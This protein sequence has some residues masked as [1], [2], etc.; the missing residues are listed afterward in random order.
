MTQLHKIKYWLKL[1]NLFFGP[2]IARII[3]YSDL[4][5]TRFLLGVA[6]LIWGITL[7]LP[8]QTFGRP[9]YH[10]MSFVMSEECWGAVFLMTSFLQFTILLS[11]RYHD[12]VS[13]VFAAW[14]TLLWLFVVGGMYMSVY[15][16]PAGISGELTLALAAGWVFARSGFTIEGRRS[17]DYGQ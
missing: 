4:H 15:P 14:N 8:G 1:A 3:F 11:G 10:V 5:G 9:T 17:T 7:L 6:E 12:R 16:I 2:R 13:I